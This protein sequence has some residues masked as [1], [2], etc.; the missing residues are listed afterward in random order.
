MYVLSK[1]IS[2]KFIRVTTTPADKRN[3]LKGV[4]EFKICVS[5]PL[6]FTRVKLAESPLSRQFKKS[7]KEKKLANPEWNKIT[8]RRQNQVIK[9]HVQSNNKESK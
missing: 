3:I 2:R 7:P 5:V 4:L 9:Y 6:N 8:S 1:R